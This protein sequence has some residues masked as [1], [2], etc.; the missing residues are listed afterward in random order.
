MAAPNPVA[1][2]KPLSGERLLDIGIGEPARR[3]LHPAG[4]DS[5][6]EAG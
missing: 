4:R 2:L 5:G 3:W 6:E 1:L